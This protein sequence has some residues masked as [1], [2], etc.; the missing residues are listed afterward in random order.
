[1]AYWL[2]KGGGRQRKPV[3]SYLEE[4]VLSSSLR[5]PQGPDPFRRQK[6]E[7]A[8]MLLVTDQCH[9]KSAVR[10]AC[11]LCDLDY[12]NQ[13]IRKAVYK[14]SNLDEPRKAELVAAAQLAGDMMPLVAAA[15]PDRLSE[16]AP[17]PLAGLPPGLSKEEAIKWVT[18]RIR[19]DADAGRVIGKLSVRDGA[20]LLA[21][22]Y[23]G[24][25][26]ISKSHVARY[27]KDI[28]GKTPPKNG[29]GHIAP[30]WFCEK[31]CDFAVM[32]RKTLRI[33]VPWTMIIKASL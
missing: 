28:P 12:D 25:K 26:G 9:G 31:L 32:I 4:S 20:N 6:I 8:A 10:Q 14:Q 2:S 15:K 24:A 7:R 11:E 22:Q 29:R 5:T 18:A 16:I 1:M 21:E 19:A 30:K 27:S 17:L 33:R 23:H 13:T 3:G